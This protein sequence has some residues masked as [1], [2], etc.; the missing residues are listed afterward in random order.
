MAEYSINVTGAA[1][2]DEVREAFAATVRALRAAGDDV[3]GGLVI[4][5]VP[6][7]AED[8]PDD[9]AADTDEEADA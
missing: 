8:V 9:D 4:E 3:T 6:Y 7:A 5:G 2:A 1:D